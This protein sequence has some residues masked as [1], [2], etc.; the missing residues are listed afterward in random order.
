[1]DMEFSHIEE[2]RNRRKDVRHDNAMNSLATR[3]MLRPGNDAEV[4]M[5]RH[6]FW[7]VDNLI[8]I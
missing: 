6:R 7:L 8:D 4:G 2:A 3:C 5:P 1:M